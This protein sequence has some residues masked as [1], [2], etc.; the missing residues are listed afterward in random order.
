MKK[1]GAHVPLFFLCPALCGRACQTQSACRS[2][3]DGIISECKEQG[4]NAG[5]PNT[6]G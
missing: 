6:S 4:G 5:F 3:T 2:Y 1:S